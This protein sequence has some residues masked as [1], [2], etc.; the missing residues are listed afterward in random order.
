MQ[1]KAVDASDAV[2][3][4]FKII[5]KLHEGEKTTT[6]IWRF[7][8]DQQYTLQTVCYEVVQLFP[9]ITK[10]G[11]N[12]ELYHFDD[13]AGQVS[14]ESDADMEEALRNFKEESQSSKPRTEYMTL[15]ANDCVL[16]IQVANEEDET[17]DKQ[18]SRKVQ[19]NE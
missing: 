4:H 5:V 9:Q 19:I 13:L 2:A 10:R 16:P 12:V 1:S 7:K 14:I 17:S 11:V 18:P 6:K 3:P 8:A 15:H